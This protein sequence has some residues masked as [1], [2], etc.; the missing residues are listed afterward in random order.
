MNAYAHNKVKL[1]RLVQK[2]RNVSVRLIGKKIR[3]SV[4]A[5]NKAIP[6]C[7]AGLMQTNRVSQLIGID[8][9]SWMKTMRHKG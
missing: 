3:R 1:R 2:E 7:G 6:D 5:F 9:D 4:A 8:A